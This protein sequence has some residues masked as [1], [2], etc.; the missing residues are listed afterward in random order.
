LQAD[1][2]T[3]YLYIMQARYR[4][5]SAMSIDKIAWSVAYATDLTSLSHAHRSLSGS[6][7]LATQDR[8]KLHRWLLRVL[9]D[10]IPPLPTHS[11]WN[12]SGSP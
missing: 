9:V 1:N 3:K 8:P 7:L 6:D 2:R 12:V 10:P 5:S 11:P 4:S